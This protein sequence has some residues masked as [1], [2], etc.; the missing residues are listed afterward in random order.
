MSQRIGEIF[1][2]SDPIGSGWSTRVNVA[3]EA[4]KDSDIFNFN[5]RW[6]E[7]PNFLNELKTKFGQLKFV[8]TTNPK[9]NN[10]IGLFKF[11]WCH[12]R[13]QSVKHKKIEYSLSNIRRFSKYTR[14]IRSAAMI[15]KLQ[16]KT[17]LVTSSYRH[18]E[19]QMTKSFR[20]TNHKMIDLLWKRLLL[21]IAF[22]WKNQVNLKNQASV[23]ANTRRKW[24]LKTKRKNREAKCANVY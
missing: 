20:L 19:F 15:L 9:K 10:F 14:L 12:R 21:Q 8:W 3:D 22:L 7:G 2:N 6:F 23:V 4:P 24:A 17:L 18:N 11:R 13:T 1:E 16:I 5:N